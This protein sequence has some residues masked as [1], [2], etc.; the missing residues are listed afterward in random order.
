MQ[1]GSGG[2]LTAACPRLAHWGPSLTQDSRGRGKPGSKEC[3]EQMPPE[4]EERALALRLIICG[5]RVG[6]GTG[7]QQLLGLPDN[8]GDLLFQLFGVPSSAF[9]YRMI[10][11]SFVSLL[12][13]LHSSSFNRHRFPGNYPLLYLTIVEENQVTVT[14]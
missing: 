5:R 11:F 3:V 13:F 4:Q 12:P 7:K 8:L 2:F 6:E 9:L 1:R 10:A 14:S